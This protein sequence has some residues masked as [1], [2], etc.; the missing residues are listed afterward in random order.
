MTVISWTDRQVLTRVR[1]RPIAA[2]ALVAVGLALPFIAAKIV[3]EGYPTPLVLLISAFL[4]GSLF[5]FVVVAGA[6]LRVVAPRHPRPPAWL[7]T[8]VVACAAGTVAFA[9][10]DT[11]LEHQ[12]VTELSALYFGAC[13]A[14]GA[15]GL[16]L[17]TLWHFRTHRTPGDRR[18]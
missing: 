17:Q 11:L 8:L 10:H 18:R 5:A 12:T 7:V 9:F 13:V 6:Y 1:A 15:V 4:T 2:A 3:R 14:A 16:A